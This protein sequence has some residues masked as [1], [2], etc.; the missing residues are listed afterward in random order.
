MA[1]N[2]GKSVRWGALIGYTLFAVLVF[3]AGLVAT[4]PV[5][6]VSQLVAARV[7]KQTGWKLT[8][9]GAAL[10][11]PSTLRFDRVATEPP[12]GPALALNDVALRVDLMQLKR[13]VIAVDHEAT[14]YG[15]TLKGHLE[16]AGPK[17]EPAYQWQGKLARIDLARLPL[18]PPGVPL[19]PWAEGLTVA[20]T[21]SSNGAIGW[22]SNQVLRGNGELDLEAQDIVI[23]AP[24]TPMGKMT[25]PVGQLTGRIKW[26]RG[27][28]DVTDLI[29]DGDLVQARGNGRIMMGPTP[30]QTRLDLRLSGELGSAFPMREL[31]SGLLQTKDKPVTITIRGN[32]AN[33]QLYIN[34]KTI[35]RL[36]LG[37]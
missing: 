9:K 4:F 28:L 7:T 24:T 18:P 13:Q 25:L 2:E 14:G 37:R 30:R 27:R 5:E 17:D 20:G 12:A 15:G 31:V 36:M 10:G 33:P 23:V 29:L 3:L 26:Q 8:L 22:R 16:V 11:L 19:A 1:A 32:M 34:G 6:R 35:N 21:L